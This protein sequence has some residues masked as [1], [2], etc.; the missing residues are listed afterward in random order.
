MSS[1]FGT[2]LVFAYGLL[3]IGFGALTIRFLIDT[4]RAIAGTIDDRGSGGGG[5]ASEP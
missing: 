3:P 2:P 1:S 5:A 4:I